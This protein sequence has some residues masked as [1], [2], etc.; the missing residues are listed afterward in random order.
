[1]EELSEIEVVRAAGWLEDAKTLDVM[2]QA[3]IGLPFVG[4]ASESAIAVKCLSEPELA[5]KGEKGSREYREYA[6]IIVELLEPVTYHNKKK[7]QDVTLEAGTKAKFNGKRHG[8]L[9]KGIQRNVPLTGKELVIANLGA[10]KVRGFPQP[11]YDYR[12]MSLANLKKK[13]GKK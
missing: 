10:R 7:N 13:L 1:M 3:P 6:W 5:S 9:W 4:A 11:V 2:R 8:A 12:I